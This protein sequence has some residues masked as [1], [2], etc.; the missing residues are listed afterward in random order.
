MS[1]N[2][3]A[4]TQGSAIERNYAAFL[5]SIER[6]NWERKVFYNPNQVRE[7][8]LKC[9]SP[10]SANNATKLLAANTSN[11][12]DQIRAEQLQD[13]MLVFATLVHPEVRLGRYMLSFMRLR[14]HD[15]ALE[16]DH[17]NY[18]T[19]RRLPPD[20]RPDDASLE[21]FEKWRWAFVPVNIELHMDHYLPIER[22]ILPFCRRDPVAYKQGGTSTVNC[23]T[24]QEDLL[25]PNVKER[26]EHSRHFDKEFR[27]VRELQERVRRRCPSSCADETVQCYKMA[28]KSYYPGWEDTYDY[29]L[30]AFKGVDG[31]QGFVQCLG[32]YQDARIVSRDDKA[33]ITR[34]ILLEYGEQD[35]DEYLA[36][37]YPPILH[38]E[39]LK[40]WELLFKVA[41]SIE[42][43]H[44]LKYE[45][46][47]HVRVNLKG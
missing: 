24:I 12:F 17:I 11:D 34:H 27:W 2:I 41:D 14:F 28:V 6:R 39:I 31:K 15:K 3:P 21:A 8:M 40:F 26:I 22:V 23:F 4:H 1:S 25:S 7:W 33:A 35:L 32:S 13:Y 10:Q 46:Q 18:E 47:A 44:N 36:E 16:H 5:S 45:N 29:E 19:L 38:S 42:K 37:M 20:H 30:Q 9:D 43:L